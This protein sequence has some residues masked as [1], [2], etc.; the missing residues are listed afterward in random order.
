MAGATRAADAGRIKAM[1]KYMM[2][3][4]F[5]LDSF[6]FTFDRLAFLPSTTQGL[7]KAC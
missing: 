5:T 3:G 7:S 6:G 2:A 4:V 1:L